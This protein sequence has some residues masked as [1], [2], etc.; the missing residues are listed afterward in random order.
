M[1]A[2]TDA[3][4]SLDERYRGLDRFQC[5]AR[6]L[7]IH[8]PGDAG[9]IPLFLSHFRSFF[10]VDA[11]WPSTTVSLPQF[12]GRILHTAPKTS[13]D[14]TGPGFSLCG[15]TGPFTL[16]DLPISTRK[17]PPEISNKSEVSAW[18]HDKGA[19]EICS[20]EI[21]YVAK[22]GGEVNASISVDTLTLGSGAAIVTNGNK[23]NIT[24]NRINSENAKVVSFFDN[25]GSARDGSYGMPGTNGQSGGSV[26][27]VI[28]QHLEGNLVVQLPG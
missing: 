14:A 10:A 11:F 22:I 8:L 15:K 12:A 21:V 17:F 7:P 2:R 24:A 19:L 9:C 6:S 5:R 18:L 20:G 25:D 13:Y 16:D 4:E 23:L 1:I 26:N 27:L 3:F 28:V